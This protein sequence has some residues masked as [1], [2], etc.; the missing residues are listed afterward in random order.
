M[1]GIH[2]LWQPH[3]E[4]DSDPPWTL[5]TSQ[6]PLRAPRQHN[7]NAYSHIVSLRQIRITRPAQIQLCLHIKA[8][9]YPSLKISGSYRQHRSHCIKPASPATLPIQAV[10]HSMH[11]P[12]VTRMTWNVSPRT[13]IFPERFDAWILHVTKARASPGCTQ[14]PS[15]SGQDW[16]I[17]ASAPLR[18]SLTGAIMV[19]SRLSLPPLCSSLPTHKYTGHSV[20]CKN[21]PPDD[22]VGFS[23]VEH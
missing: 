7:G 19:L 15:L 11:T 6:S 13:P 4:C 18:S 16:R 3:S 23:H 10:G 20:L 17:A 9:L 8:I 22:N 1:P 5:T 2:E 14:G 12:S 21:S